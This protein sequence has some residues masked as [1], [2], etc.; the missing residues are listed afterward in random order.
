MW[1]THGPLRPFLPPWPHFPPP[2]CSSVSP[3]LSPLLRQHQMGPV[4]FLS[5]NFPL[6]PLALLLSLPGLPFTLQCPAQALPALWGCSLVLILSSV[7]YQIWNT[8]LLSD[9]S[10]HTAAVH[11]FF[12]VKDQRVNMF[13]FVGHRVFDATTQICSCN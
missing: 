9:S 7:H 4:D 1:P 5:P 11:K 8:P 12:S 2:L 13:G 10:H 3:A 6:V